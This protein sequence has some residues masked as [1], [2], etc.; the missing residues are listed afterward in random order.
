MSH[1]NSL[2]LRKSHREDDPMGT[3]KDGSDY[4]NQ[5]IM[6]AKMKIIQKKYQEAIDTLFQPL[7]KFLEVRQ[8]KPS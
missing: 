7:K 3:Q 6:E 8:L 2:M 5:L 4:V 1:Q